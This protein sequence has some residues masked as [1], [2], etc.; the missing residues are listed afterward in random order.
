MRTRTQTISIPARWSGPASS[1]LPILILTLAL[2]GLL[3]GCTAEAAPPAGQA[4][5]P[6]ASVAKPVRQDVPRTLTVPARIEAVERVELRPQVG[7]YLESISFEEGEWVQRGTVLFRIDSRPYRARVA[8]A[9]ASF[10]QARV[11]YIEAARQ[12]ERGERLAVR[13][14]IPQEEAERRRAVADSSKAKIDLAQAALERARLD[15]EF[16]VVRA[17]ISGRIGRAEVT[18]G[19]LVSPESRLAVIVATDPVYVTFD[20]DESTVTPEL[21]SKDEWQIGFTVPGGLAPLPA[22]L[23]FLDNEISQGTGTLRVRGEL[24]Y[25]GG[26]VTAG[27]YGTATLTFG[28]QKDAMLVRDEAIGADQGNRFVLAVGKDETLEYR[29]VTLGPRVGNLR[30]ITSGI[31]PDDRIVVSGL[32]RLRPGTAVNPM[33]VTMTESAPATAAAKG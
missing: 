28:V 17:P 9:E 1:I 11:D 31:A 16:T 32:F 14:A 27:Q 13:N 19:N 18:R 24:R 22:K 7:G 20:I 6:P 30:V 8:E 15:L 12:A 3:A 25:G 29:K 5:L 26:A 4:S 10:M 33:E 21:A 23:A 2:A